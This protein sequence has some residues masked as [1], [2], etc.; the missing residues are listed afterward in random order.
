MQ[1]STDKVC[2]NTSE[3]LDSVLRAHQGIERQNTFE[4]LSTSFVTGGRSDAIPP[5]LGHRRYPCRCKSRSRIIRYGVRRVAAITA[6]SKT[7]YGKRGLAHTLTPLR[8]VEV[9]P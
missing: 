3:F 2:S 4:E 1:M 5:Q 6:E 9:I 7:E 8:S